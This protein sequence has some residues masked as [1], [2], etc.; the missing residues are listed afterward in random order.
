MSN[1]FN[2]SQAVNTPF[3]F[4]NKLI[5]GNFRVNQRGGAPYT[6]NS[7]T[8]TYTLDRWYGGGKSAAGVFTVGTAFDP[9]EGSVRAVLT[10]T[11]AAGSLAA[12]DGYVFAQ[13]IEGNIVSG[14]RYGTAAAKTAVLSFKAKA[15]AAG[16]Y[17]GSLMNGAADRSFPFTFDIPVADVEVSVS[18][19][20][21]GDT[22]GV[23]DAGSGIGV[24]VHFSLGSGS[25]R[26]G[27]AGA[28]AAGTYF[29]A[30]GV[31]SPILSFGA[32]LA[33]GEVQLEE[34]TVATPFEQRPY[35]LELSLCQRYY[36]RGSFAS[37]AGVT[38]SAIVA[39]VYT[40]VPFL[41]EK[42]VTPIVSGTSIQGTF[43]ANVSNTPGGS[44]MG[45]SNVVADRINSGT[46]QADAEL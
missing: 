3:S 36:E 46:W 24:R 9:A 44:A 15:S 10:V 39:S 5:N 8:N 7:P 11:T 43:S 41:V 4:R 23:W 37:Y 34:G 45:R 20:I 14:L 29:T 21:P 25:S 1:N 2:L 32:T 35:G 31:S 28:W 19:V 6:I 26:A 40:W 27:A 33:V 30:T 38:N 12:T 17:G 13:K 16:T 42:R 22:G 18:V